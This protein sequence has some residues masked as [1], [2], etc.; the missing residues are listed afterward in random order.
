MEKPTQGILTRLI[1]AGEPKDRIKG[2]ALVPI[3]QG[4]V[5]ECSDELAYG[6]IPYPRLSNMPNHL[7]LHEK[8]ADI[9]G[10]EQALV[11]SSGMSA[12]STSLLGLLEAGDH[13][14][15]QDTL[16]GGTHGLNTRFLPKLGFSCTSV[17]LTQPGTWE[18]ALQPQTRVFY[19]ET[20]TNP[21][22]EVGDL[23]AVVKFC[24]SH[25]L[26]AVIDNTFA[27]PINFRPAQ[28]GFD[29][30]VNSASKYLNGHSDLIAGAL[31]GTEECVSRIK[32]ALDHFGGSL[33]PHAC[34][35]L[36][37]GLRTLG[38]RVRTQ[39][40]NAM[41]LAT[42]LESHDAVERVHYT[43]LPSSAFHQR[44]SRLLDG[45]GG[46]LSFECRG[47]TVAAKSM[48]E[49]LKLFVC[50]PSLGR[51]ESLITRPATTSHAGMSAEER[52]AAGITDGL[53]RVAVGIEDVSD[54]IADME[55]ALA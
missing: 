26:Y 20:L 23:E 45:H 30:E 7:V 42:F 18:A 25:G 19:V 6:D 55:Q 34:F 15:T 41:R 49:K 11:T 51:V 1:H 50:G 12:I 14:I 52:A 48:M 9:S 13:I 8:L 17:D 43:G 10:A 21:L 35:M 22:L 54:L 27:S 36:H 31:M 33:D 46:V 28:W 53:I 44:A 39:N 37:R 2:A 47:G 38:L 5:Y 24:R 16:Y 4:N 40:K 3:F 29:L 32:H